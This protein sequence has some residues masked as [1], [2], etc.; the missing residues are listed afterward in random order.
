MIVI[1]S[2]LLFRL[3]AY[4]GDYHGPGV[5]VAA[6]RSMPLPHPPYLHPQFPDACS[7][8]LALYAA[9]QAHAQTARCDGGHAAG[10]RH[11]YYWCG[12][13]FG[14]NWCSVTVL[15]P[16]AGGWCRYCRS[17]FYRGLQRATERRFCNYLFGRASPS[18]YQTTVLD[19]CVETLSYLTCSIHFVLH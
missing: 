18:P 14:D 1:L 3:N 5:A 13:T 11:S 8:Y 7:R 15:L 9:L 19:R 2:L 17:T 10:G 12:R 4:G 6:P 16:G